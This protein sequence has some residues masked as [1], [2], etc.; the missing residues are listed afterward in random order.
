MTIRFLLPEE[1]PYGALSN[2]VRSPIEIRGIVYQTPEHYI[3][4]NMLRS[5][6]DQE[7][8]RNTYAPNDVRNLYVFYKQQENLITVRNALERGYRTLVNTSL[9][10]K[11]AL[12][13]TGSSKL[14]YD[15]ADPVLGGETNLVGQVL[16]QIRS[17]VN[18]AT[19]DQI[20]DIF[21]VY[22]ELKRRLYNGEPVLN[23]RRVEYPKYIYNRNATEQEYVIED[24]NRGKLPYVDIEIRNPGS[25]AQLVLNDHLKRAIN[26][27]QD[28]LKE[29][30]F[31]VFLAY[32]GRIN[33]VTPTMLHSI[34]D[35]QRLVD[36]VY[37]MYKTDKLPTKVIDEIKT[38]VHVNPDDLIEVVAD[39]IKEDMTEDVFEQEETIIPIDNILSPRV[40]LYSG[41]LLT[42]D[43]HQFPTVLHYVYYKLMEQL[44]LIVDK[45]QQIKN[46]NN[47]KRIN[48]IETIFMNLQ[49][50]ATS[51]QLTQLTEEV[52]TIKFKVPLF[53]NV[54]RLT[55][56][57][58][59]VY[60]SP[61]PFLGIGSDNNGQNIVGKVLEGIRKTLPKLTEADIQYYLNDQ[62]IISRIIDL[63]RTLSLVSRLFRR[64]DWSMM[65]TL[66]V[67]RSLYSSCSWFSVVKM[68]RET[69]EKMRAYTLDMDLEINSNGLEVVYSYIFGLIELLMSSRDQDRLVRKSIESLNKPASAQQAA[70]AVLT[71]ADKLAHLRSKLDNQEHRMDAVVFDVAKKIVEGTGHLHLRL[72]KFDNVYIPNG[73]AD[74][75]MDVLVSLD[76]NWSRLRFFGDLYG[77]TP[78]NLMMETVRVE[79]NKK[80]EDEYE[81]AT[82]VFDIDEYDPAQVFDSI[83]E[84]DPV[85]PYFNPDSPI[86][87]PDTPEY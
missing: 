70:D 37:D 39:E 73:L 51:S 24:Y 27:R 23:V 71:V 60:A 55:G 9:E 67:V 12:L 87:N 20:Y 68:S 11:Q 47:F 81:P 7:A 35:R 15:S 3:Y 13:E 32:V 72:T 66:Q 5:P 56:K 79:D 43:R 48:D 21:L 74:L 41:F 50:Y 36:R 82:Q 80:D 34:Q 58:K 86:Y 19:Y 16:E 75:V 77:Q 44:P 84:Y 65:N 8:V 38:L 25:L 78:V 42:I 31:S 2:E 1:R 22:E 59:L 76:V 6:I 53:I 26:F 29:T 64:M 10:I 63:F 61:D 57:D 17:E 14:V 45:Y 69:E 62:V 18:A 28:R 52:L 4:S 40:Q 46:G 83:D 30:I 85:D 49:A 54:L 33:N